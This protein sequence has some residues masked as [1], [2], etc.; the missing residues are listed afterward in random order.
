MI[1]AE[2]PEIGIDAVAV[3]P[4]ETPTPGDRSYLVHDGEVAFVVDPQRDI[5]RVL[6]LPGQRGLRLTHVLESRTHNDYVTGGLALA[7]RTGAEYLAGLPVT[8]PAAA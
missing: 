8:V 2:T 6:A 5:D 7:R 1:P 4:L 3:I